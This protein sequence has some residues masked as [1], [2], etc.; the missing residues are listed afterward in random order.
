[1][2][3]MA[4]QHIQNMIDALGS[5]QNNAAA[6]DHFNAA[7]QQKIAHELDAKRV[8]VAKSMFGQNDDVEIEEP[9]AEVETEDEE[10]QAAD[11]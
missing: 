2:E 4:K 5:D 3:D 11:E 10:I 9:E 1:M 8:D 6:L 7:M